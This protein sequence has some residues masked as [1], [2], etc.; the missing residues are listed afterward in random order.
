MGDLSLK[1]QLVGKRDEHVDPDVFLA[2][3]AGL[4]ESPLLIERSSHRRI[5]NGDRLYLSRPRLADDRT[6]YLQLWIMRERFS[7]RLS[8]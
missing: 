3:R 2:V 7:Y 5:R 4:K 1:T 6:R 8:A